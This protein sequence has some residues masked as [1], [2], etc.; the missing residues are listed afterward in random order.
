MK[1]SETMMLAVMNATQCFLTETLEPTNAFITARNIVLLDTFFSK[2]TFLKS[3]K[4]TLFVF[5]LVFFLGNIE[6]I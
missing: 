1:S 6:E 2:N 4:N 3:S 5:I